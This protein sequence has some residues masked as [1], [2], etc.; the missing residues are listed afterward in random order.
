MSEMNYHQIYH[1]FSYIQGEP[2]TFGL[3]DER[4]KTTIIRNNKGIKNKKKFSHVYTL[5]QN[6]F[7]FS[8]NTFTRKY[9]FDGTTTF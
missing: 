4:K 3:K 9:H 7:A 2:G 1:I 6:R 5:L 8:R